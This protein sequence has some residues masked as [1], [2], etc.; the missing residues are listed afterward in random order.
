VKKD[1]EDSLWTLRQGWN[2]LVDGVEDKYSWKFK[3][4]AIPEA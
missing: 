4:L 3:K 2:E 1:I